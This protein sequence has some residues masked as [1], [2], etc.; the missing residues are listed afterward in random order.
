MAF[1]ARAT[2][3]QGLSGKPKV[4]RDNAFVISG[5]TG[6]IQ[7]LNQAPLESAGEIIHLLT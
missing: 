4:V 1:S 3:T 6:L 7:M 5:T 2:S